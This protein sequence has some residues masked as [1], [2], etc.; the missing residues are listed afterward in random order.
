MYL[1]T[2]HDTVYHM[3]MWHHRHCTIRHLFYMVYELISGMHYIYLQAHCPMFY[4]A[5]YRT[6]ARLYGFE[7]HM[8]CVIC[9][10][11]YVR[12]SAVHITCYLESHILWPIRALRAMVYILHIPCMTYLVACSTYYA[13]YTRYTSSNHKL[14]NAIR[15]TNCR[16]HGL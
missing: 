1:H 5:Y 2:A 6:Y 12:Y 13:S 14:H 7:F 11:Q 4:I 15:I 3:H 10:G 16:V 9:I 8:K